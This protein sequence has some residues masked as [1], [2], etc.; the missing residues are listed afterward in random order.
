MGKNK[1]FFMAICLLT[2][3]SCKDGQGDKLLL[4]SIEQTWQLCETSLPDA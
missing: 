4:N 3:L 2:L 1:L